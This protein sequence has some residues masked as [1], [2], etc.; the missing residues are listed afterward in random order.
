V[1]AAVWVIVS[2]SAPPSS[3]SS[4]V[5]VTVW[6]VSQLPVVKVRLEEDT[7]TVS[8]SLLATVRV[9]SDDGSLASFTW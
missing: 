5:T 6:A 8:V 4:A 3:S 7:V 1:L 2:S 9:T